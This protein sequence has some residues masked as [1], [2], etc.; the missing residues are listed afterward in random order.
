M[1]VLFCFVLRR[2]YLTVHLFWFYI[3]FRGMDMMASCSST[4][5]AR[6]VNVHLYVD[7]YLCRQ[8]RAQVQG[9]LRNCA[10]YYAG[11]SAG[12]SRLHRTLWT[13][14]AGP[15]YVSSCRTQYVATAS[16]ERYTSYT[17]ATQQHHIMWQLCGPFNFYIFNVTAS[18]TRKL[19][20]ESDTL[21]HTN[22]SCVCWRTSV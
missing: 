4:I 17:A 8:K 13:C 1:L 18:C 6:W 10:A 20:V 21:I 12:S 14:Q 9:D 2:W 11:H 22:I 3:C 5:T 15:G 16:A 7:I 19:I